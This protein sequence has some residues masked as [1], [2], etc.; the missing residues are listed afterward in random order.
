MRLLG[1]AVIGAGLMLP[2]CMMARDAVSAVQNLPRPSIIVL[3]PEPYP[4][5][6]EGLI[7]YCRAV[8]ERFEFGRKRVGVGNGLLEQGR[9]MVSEGSY[10]I[11][12]GEAKIKA[13][14]T[15]LGNARRTLGLKLG[16]TD[17]DFED[18]ELLYNPKFRSRIDTE[19]ANGLRQMQRGQDMIEIGERRV[20]EGRARID[21]GLR[22]VREGQSAMLDDEGRC[23]PTS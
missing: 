12:A 14:E 15:A 10:R 17:P 22:I 21:E 1:F 20:A 18:A 8:K 2:G 7:E 19:L 13:G 23:R 11:R 4:V 6:S 3:D 16:N 5:D 9:A